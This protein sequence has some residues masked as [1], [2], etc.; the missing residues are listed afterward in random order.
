MAGPR[1]PPAASVNRRFP[2]HPLVGVA[3]LVFREQSVLLV[4][5]GREP[6][7]GLWSLPGGLVELGERLDQAIEREVLEECGLQVQA[8]DLVAALD[9]VIRSDDGRVEYH[10]VLLDFICRFRSETEQPQASSDALAGAFVPLADLDSYPM[11]AGTLDVIRRVWKKNRGT[12]TE[13]LY[14]PGT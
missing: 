7:Y 4:Q 14:R 12:S 11:T 10:Y 8:Q 13:P 6:G 5:R 2:Q 3:A 9:R 1:M